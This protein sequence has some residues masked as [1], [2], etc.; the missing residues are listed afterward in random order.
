MIIILNLLTFFEGGRGCLG[1]F[2]FFFSGGGGG[3]ILF[4]LG[5]E[6]I[7]LV[8]VGIKCEHRTDNRMTQDLTI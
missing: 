1:S 6:G 4:F 7:E 2:G 8:K 3:V 5:G